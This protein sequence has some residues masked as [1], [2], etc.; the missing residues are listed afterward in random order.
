MFF[1]GLN[2]RNKPK[3][4]RKLFPAYYFGKLNIKDKPKTSKKPF[5]AYYK[6]TS[7]VKEVCLTCF[8]QTFII[9]KNGETL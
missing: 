2:I 5:P 8:R 4:S 1:V 6:D 7:F 9:L 3:T